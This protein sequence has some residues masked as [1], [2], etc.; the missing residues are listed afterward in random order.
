MNLLMWFENR[1]GDEGVNLKEMEG[2]LRDVSS[3]STACFII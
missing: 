1:E 2:Y 3:S